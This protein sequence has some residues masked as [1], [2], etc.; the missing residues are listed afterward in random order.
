[1]DLADHKKKRRFEILTPIDCLG[2]QHSLVDMRKDKAVLYEKLS[3]KKSSPE[4]LRYFFTYTPSMS[5]TQKARLRKA[6]RKTRRS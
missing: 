6:L 2:T 4:F 3:S 1:M 5:K